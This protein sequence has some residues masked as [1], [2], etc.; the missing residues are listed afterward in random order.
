MFYVKRLDIN[1][2]FI[3]N[4]KVLRMKN[5]VDTNFPR[6]TKSRSIARHGV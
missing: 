5:A 2:P 1:Q 6:L 3:A 4:E